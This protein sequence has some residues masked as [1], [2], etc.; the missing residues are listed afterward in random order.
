M[1][2]HT[3]NITHK[4]QTPNQLVAIEFN[5]YYN[6]KILRGQSVSK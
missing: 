4:R 1:K 6:V 2:T 3:L 5:R